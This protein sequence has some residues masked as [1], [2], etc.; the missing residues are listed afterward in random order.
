MKLVYHIIIFFALALMLTAC[1][2]DAVSGVGVQAGQSFDLPIGQSAILP[3]GSNRLVFAQVLK[4]SRCPRLID[5]FGQGRAKVKMVLCNSD[6]SKQD[7]EL[8]QGQSQVIQL[9]GLPRFKLNL[10]D[11]FPLPGLNR[12]VR[13]E[14]YVLRLA[15]D[16]L[17]PVQP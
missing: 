13:P 5:C 11:L 10:I 3:G 7:I 16:E 1:G 6:N 9:D 12:T 17:D 2:D 14:E 15:L 8:T 4:D